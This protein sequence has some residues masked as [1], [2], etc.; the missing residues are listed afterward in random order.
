MI[1]MEGKKRRGELVTVKCTECGGRIRVS[2][3]EAKFLKHA[4]KLIRVTNL[5]LQCHETL[6]P[7]E[8]RQ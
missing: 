1:T 7:K 2:A 3:D 5:C 4:A 8:L 6:K